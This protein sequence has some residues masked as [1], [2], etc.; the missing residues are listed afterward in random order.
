MQAPAAELL[1]NVRACRGAANAL[2]WALDMAYREEGSRLRKG[3]G[4]VKFVPLR[5][6]AVNLLKQERSRKISIKNKRLP[7]GWGHDYPW[8]VLQPILAP[9]RLATI[10]GCATFR[11]D[12]EVSLVIQK[13]MSHPKIQDGSCLLLCLSKHGLS[14][15]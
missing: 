4:A 15:G 5:D 8:A 11:T 1:A 2:P 7:A 6:I 14:A 13:S 3:A 12:M 10:L 9:G